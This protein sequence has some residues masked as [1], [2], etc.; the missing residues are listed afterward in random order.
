MTLKFVVMVVLVMRGDDVE[1]C[2]VG[3]DDDVARGDEVEVCSDGGDDDVAVMMLKCIAM[4]M[5]MVVMI[6]AR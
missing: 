3:G 4:V 1:A 6:I 5:M 2:S